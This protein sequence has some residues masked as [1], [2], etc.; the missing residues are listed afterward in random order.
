MRRFVGTCEAVAATTKKT[1]KVTLVSELF[2]SLPLEDAASA[3]IF[4]TGR[5]FPHRDERVL[6]VGGSQLA[7]IVTEIAKA[8]PSELGR[9][10]RAH[11]DVGDIA[12]HLLLRRPRTADVPLQQLAK[13]FSQLSEARTAA[14]KMVLIK[15]LFERMSAGEV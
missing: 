9:S 3:A 6:G 11:G 12:E 13:T 5:P 2:K 8:D 1:A 10:Y 4:I 14:Q 15:N 7:K